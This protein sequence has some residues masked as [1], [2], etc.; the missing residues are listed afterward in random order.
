[1]LQDEPEGLALEKPMLLHKPTVWNA[2]LLVSMQQIYISYWMG[3]R[4]ISLGQLVRYW[5][6]CLA[7]MYTNI[8]LA[9]LCTPISY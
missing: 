4:P 6:T 1:M 2:A 7:I 3:S 8:L 5:C 9:V